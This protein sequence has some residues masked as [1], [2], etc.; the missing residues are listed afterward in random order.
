MCSSRFCVIKEH[1]MGPS[2]SV[3]RVCYHIVTTVT[4]ENIVAMIT[5]VHTAATVTLVTIVAFVIHLVTLLTSSP[6]LWLKEHLW[7]SST[8]K[9]TPSQSC[10]R[11]VLNRYF[12]VKIFSLRLWNVRSEKMRVRVC[13]YLINKSKSYWGGFCVTHT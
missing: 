6:L 2:M 3:Y 10:F 5:M 12:L 7:I 11:N 9:S 1:I 8:S 4:L 13:I